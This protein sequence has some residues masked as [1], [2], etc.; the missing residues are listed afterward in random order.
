MGGIEYSLTQE[1][2]YNTVTSIVMMPITLGTLF[3]LIVFAARTKT[4][5]FYSRIILALLI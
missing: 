5:M 4:F 3:I 2:E 1:F